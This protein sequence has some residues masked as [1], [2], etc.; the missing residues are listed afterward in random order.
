MPELNG[1]TDTQHR[2]FPGYDPCWIH[3]NGQQMRLVWSGDA[4]AALAYRNKSR[5][6]PYTSPKEDPTVIAM[7]SR[8]DLWIIDC[9]QAVYDLSKTQESADSKEF[10]AF[11]R[12]Y[13]G[14]ISALDVEA[15][16]TLLCREVMMLSLRGWTGHVSA[17][18]NKGGKVHVVDRQCFCQTRM[19]NIVLALR[20]S[21]TICMGIIMSNDAILDLAN[22]PSTLRF[23]QLAERKSIL[24]KDDRNTENA[25]RMPAAT[26][27][28]STPVPQAVS[29]VSHGVILPPPVHGPN[30][31]P[32]VPMVP[33]PYVPTLYPGTAFEISNTEVPNSAA[34]EGPFQFSGPS[35]PAMGMNAMPQAGQSDGLY[36]MGMPMMTLPP[37]QLQGFVSTKTPFYMIGNHMHVEI[38]PDFNPPV[39]SSHAI[40]PPNLSWNTADSGHQSSPY[41]SQYQ[42][43]YPVAAATS[44]Y[45]YTPNA[46]MA[47]ASRSAA[48]PTTSQS[49]TESR[50]PSPASASRLDSQCLSSPEDFYPAGLG[51]KREWSTD[52]ENAVEDRS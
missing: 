28:Q 36:Q 27:K 34:F 25:T 10:R 37:P 9:M 46:A 23:A 5:D 49:D 39:Q 2:L 12:S 16:C 21:K 52:S 6:V 20:E 32:Q 3:A 15:A 11:N 24:W 22:A 44:H 48:A 1:I 26:R 14:S 35:N 47:S 38:M 17:N 42:P 30:F 45:N 4:D 18:I 8:Q 7:S 19:E 50:L 51:P 13:Y 43:G 40:P 29:P 31:N 33:A 41:Y